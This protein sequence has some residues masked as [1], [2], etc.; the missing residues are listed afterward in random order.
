MKSRILSRCL[1]TALVLLSL[2]NSASQAVA[3]EPADPHKL[4]EQRCAACHDPHAGIF[5]RD[6]QERRKDA[7]V[8]RKSGRELRAFLV[9]GHGRLAPLEV[10]V[11]V[12]HLTS[13]LAA[14]GL[15]RDRCLICH[16]RA[17]ELAR[18]KLIIRQGRLVGR[19]T[20][21][22]VESFLKTHG[23]IDDTQAETLLRVLARQSSS[24]PAE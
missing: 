12:Q 18:G 1:V 17:V 11:M 16:G 9:E 14:D 15:F 6:S 5:V 24:Y 3:A 21:R 4:F 19:Y 7:V 8:G 22:D 2:V 10:D 20:G 13:I 23:R